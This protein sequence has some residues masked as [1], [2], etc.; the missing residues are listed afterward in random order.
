MDIQTNTISNYNEEKT[1]EW[2]QL[3][4]FIYIYIYIY[5]NHSLLT[6]IQLKEHRNIFPAYS[7]IFACHFPACVTFALS[8]T[9]LSSIRSYS[10]ELKLVIVSELTTL[11]SFYLLTICS[12]LTCHLNYPAPLQPLDQLWRPLWERT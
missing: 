7:F 5:I 6:W 12:S 8:I 4:C 10:L 3:F 9:K 2:F 11:R 1:L